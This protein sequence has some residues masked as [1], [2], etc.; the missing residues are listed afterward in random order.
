MLRVC[1]AQAP[2]WGLFNAGQTICRHTLQ[3]GELYAPRIHLQPQPAA[4]L[5]RYMHQSI[6]DWR[7]R[8]GVKLQAVPAYGKAK[9]IYQEACERAPEQGAAR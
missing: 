7:L 1:K 3:S 2:E 8:C 6:E 5:R 9:Q 4:A